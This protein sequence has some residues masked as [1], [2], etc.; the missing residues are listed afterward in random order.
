[1]KHKQILTAIAAA[2]VLCACSP[3]ENEVAQSTSAITEETVT[4]E[5][6]E[7][8]VVSPLAREDFLTPLEDFSWEREFDPEYVMIHFTSAV[9]TD[10]SDPYNIEK[11]RRVF[12]DAGVSINYIVDRDGSVRCYVPENRA[13][14]HAGKGELAGNGKYTNKMNKYSIGIELIA[15]GSQADMAQYLTPAEYAALDQSLIGFTEAQYESLAALVKD[16]CERSSIPLDRAHVIGHSEYSEGKSDPGEL[17]NWSRI[18][19]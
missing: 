17:F 9:V 6:V 15:I 10:R 8:D 12:T 7:A 13:A 18:V 3:V 16:I 14:W 4:T 11:V 2:L 1:M 19:K 5:A